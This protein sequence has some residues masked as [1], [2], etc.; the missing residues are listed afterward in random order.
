VNVLMKLRK[1]MMIE[2]YDVWMYYLE[3]EQ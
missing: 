3:V 2:M 1:Q